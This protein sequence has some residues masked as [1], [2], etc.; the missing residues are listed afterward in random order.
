MEIFFKQFGNCHK[1]FHNQHVLRWLSYGNDV[2]DPG[3][4]RCVAFA[5]NLFEHFSHGKNCMN[6][7]TEHVTGNFGVVPPDV[8]QTTRKMKA[9]NSQKTS[10]VR[11]PGRHDCVFITSNNL[12]DFFGCLWVLHKH[13]T[14]VELTV[15]ETGYNI[16]SV[17]YWRQI[18][19]FTGLW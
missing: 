16:F 10:S 3:K 8:R 18:N 15:L 2:T 5:D 1:L 6:S 13:I 4:R 14:K 17:W 7:A 11:K 9:T 19:V 12:R